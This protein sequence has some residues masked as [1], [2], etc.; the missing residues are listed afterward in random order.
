VFKDPENT[1]KKAVGAAPLL[2]SSVR[3]FSI[4]FHFVLLIDPDQ[5]SLSHYVKRPMDFPMHDSIY[6]AVKASR[7]LPGIP[8]VNV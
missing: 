2:C 8:A 6:C 3:V 5:S 1:E 4:V 7:T